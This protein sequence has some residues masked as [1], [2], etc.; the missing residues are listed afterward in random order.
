VS[1][2]VNQGRSYQICSD[3]LSCICIQ[4]LV[5]FLR[6][7]RDC[8]FGFPLQYQSLLGYTCIQSPFPF[9]SSSLTQ[10]TA[11]SSHHYHLGSPYDFHRQLPTFNTQIVRYKN[12]GL[13]LPWVI[14]YGIHLESMESIRNSIWNPWNQH[15]L[16]PQPISYSMYIMDSMWNDDGIVME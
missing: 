9:L 8:S 11:G 1:A 4:S 10:I 12:G 15:W 7:S 5:D 13:Y 3:I 2:P 14:P 6:G 16:R